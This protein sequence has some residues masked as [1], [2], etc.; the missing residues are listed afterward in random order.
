MALSSEMG[1][2]LRQAKRVEITDLSPLIKPEPIR[3]QA[4]VTSLRLTVI[5]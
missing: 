5:S 4:I 3:L 1:A 2:G